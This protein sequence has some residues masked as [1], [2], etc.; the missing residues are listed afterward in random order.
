MLYKCEERKS[1]QLFC[2]KVIKIKYLNLYLRDL[3]TE[4][5]ILK[6]FVFK[7]LIKCHEAYFFNKYLILI[8]FLLFFSRCWFVIFEYMDRGSL[9][10]LF[11]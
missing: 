3:K 5:K 7:N 10:E 9:R 6:K 4:L 2:S 1:K 8:I 11:K